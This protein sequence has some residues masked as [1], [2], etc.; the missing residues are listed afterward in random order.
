MILRPVTMADAEE[1]FASLPDLNTVND[2]IEE[3][4]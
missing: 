2:H 4:D 1:M 3:R